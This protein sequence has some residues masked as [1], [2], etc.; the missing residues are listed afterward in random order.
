MNATKTKT[1]TEITLT[2]TVE[3]KE[4]PAPEKPKFIF[5][6]Y[7]DNSE[8]FDPTDISGFLKDGVDP[9]PYHFS[10]IRHTD[11]GIAERRYFQ[12]VR[13]DTH[14][15]M[16]KAEAFDPIHGIIGRGQQWMSHTM[17]GIPEVSL[18]I[19]P[20]EANEEELKQMN[21]ASQRR[22]DPNHNE[23]L[24]EIQDRIG[25]VIGT[26]HVSGSITT[27]RSGWNN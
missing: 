23:K 27:N 5:T 20:A 19:R 25:S 1:E 7:T 9:T 16:F 22:L 11:H 8:A 14:G 12:R 13:K 17:N 4:T 21:K 15:D 24:R 26:E 2:E 6:D 18:Y 3:V 10:W